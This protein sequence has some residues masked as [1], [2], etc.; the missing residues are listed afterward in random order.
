[1]DFVGHAHHNIFFHW[2]IKGQGQKNPTPQGNHRFPLSLNQWFWIKNDVSPSQNRR[3]FLVIIKW[4]QMSWLLRVF[5]RDF[6]MFIPECVF[7]AV[8]FFLSSL[9]HMLKSLISLYDKCWIWL[10][11]SHNQNSELTGAAD[12]PVGNRRFDEPPPSCR[13][14]RLV[15]WTHVSKDKRSHWRLFVTAVYMTLGMIKVTTGVLG[16][17]IC[18]PQASVFVADARTAWPENAPKDQELAVGNTSHL[19]RKGR[20]FLFQVRAWCIGG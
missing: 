19:S 6:H 14:N 11:Y 4:A 9:V 12:N 5:L 13:Y 17:S 1:M 10:C 3:F 2:S 15:W 18:G 8:M 16:V 7:T 20:S